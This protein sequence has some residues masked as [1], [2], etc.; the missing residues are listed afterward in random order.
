MRKTIESNN[1]NKGPPPCRSSG[2]KTTTV[3]AA[4]LQAFG[5]KRLKKNADAVR[6]QGDLEAR[7]P[8]RFLNISKEN[9]TQEI[10]SYF[11]SKSILKS[12]QTKIM[13]T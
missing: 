10:N 3:K 2:N 8:R 1:K 5:K 4:E 7:L 12:I 6:A 9:F 11:E 13:Q